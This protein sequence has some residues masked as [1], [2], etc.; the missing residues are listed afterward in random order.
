MI[1]FLKVISDN[2][3]FELSVSYYLFLVII[4]PYNLWWSLANKL[5]IWML[6]RC[7]EMCVYVLDWWIVRLGWTNCVVWGPTEAVC[8]LMKFR[9]IF[10]AGSALFLIGRCLFYRGDS[11]KFS[12]DFP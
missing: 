5:F 6:G 4:L 3:D 12:V 9:S 10:L 2:Y 7:C 11:A 1:F 8:N